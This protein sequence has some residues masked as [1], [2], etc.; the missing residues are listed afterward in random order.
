MIL[1]PACLPLSTEEKWQWKSKEKERKK[2]KNKV[3]LGATKPLFS[4]VK[5][6]IK[7]IMLLLCV[8]ISLTE[9]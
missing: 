1:E 3:S 5:Q 4:S 9:M 7:D 6:T 8:V 2:E